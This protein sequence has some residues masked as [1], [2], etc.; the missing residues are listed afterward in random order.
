MA[1]LDYKKTTTQNIKVC[2]KLDIESMTINVDGED[3]PL[4]VLFKDFDDVDD[5]VI[6]AKVKTE[7]L[8]DLPDED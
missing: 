7:E 2:G 5:L 6:T 1:N 8:L 4:K 3:I